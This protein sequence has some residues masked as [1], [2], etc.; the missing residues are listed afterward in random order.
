MDIA[1]PVGTGLSSNIQG[2]VVYAG[3]GKKGTGYNSYGIT[4]AIKDYKGNIHVY[5]HMDS[6]NVKVGQ[7]VGLG[8]LL[9]KS[10]NTGRS[11]GPHLHY[12]V[13]KNGKLGDTLD[14]SVFLQGMGTSSS[15]NKQTTKT[16][17]KAYSSAPSKVQ[18]MITSA[19]SKYKVKP[20]LVAAI[21]SVET[22]GS[23]KTNLTSSAGAYGLMQLMPV[24]GEG[25]KDPVK[26]VEIGT[27]YIHDMLK[28]YPTVEL[29]L[30][31]YNWGP[32]NLDALIKKKGTNDWNELSK[33]MPKETR[34]YIPK[35]LALL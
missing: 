11:E 24:H 20:S 32:G 9:G 30:A 6:V 28:K 1:I 16:T 33:H 7:K 10:G 15:G 34:D 13:R 5:G 18:N 3:M 2:E 12:E 8:D 19:S 25:R 14:P 4:V 23:F 26:N 31:A 17:G 27:K 29:A 22:G 21:A 35:V